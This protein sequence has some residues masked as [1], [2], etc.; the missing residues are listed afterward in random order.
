MTGTLESMTRDEAAE[1]LRVR[2][3]KVSGTVSKKTHYLVVGSDA[4]SKLDKAQKMGVA[5][6]N[7]AELR[8]MLVEA[9][10]KAAGKAKA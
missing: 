2:G 4:G 10:A 6:L 8:A 9:V 7:E 1:L 5:V 3:A